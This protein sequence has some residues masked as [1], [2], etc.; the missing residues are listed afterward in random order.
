M[1]IVPLQTGLRITV[2]VRTEI[3]VFFLGTQDGF[4]PDLCLGLQVLIV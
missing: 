4:N 1:G 3:P 2:G